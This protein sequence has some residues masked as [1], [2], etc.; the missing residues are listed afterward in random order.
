MQYSKEN[1][2]KLGFLFQNR[3]VRLAQL[4]KRLEKEAK[5]GRHEAIFYFNKGRLEAMGVNL[6]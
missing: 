4:E 3:L 1:Y 6:G 2:K 5:T